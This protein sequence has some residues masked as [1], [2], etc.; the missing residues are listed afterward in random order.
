MEGLR[1]TLDA[2]ISGKSCF[3]LN[4]SFLTELIFSLESIE[5]SALPSIIVPATM[6]LKK[7][8]R[9]SKIGPAN[10]SNSSQTS[11]ASSRTTL[12][13]SARDLPRLALDDTSSESE[14]ETSFSEAHPRP[15]SGQST[16]SRSRSAQPN[17][18]GHQRSDSRTESRSM[19]YLTLSRAK[20]ASSAGRERAVSYQSFA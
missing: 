18:G 14:A 19:D 15:K 17:S 9:K 13:Y 11:A 2:Y 3:A 8:R 6:S 10:G 1:I 12:Q 20:S 5:R 7:T 4:A 16:K